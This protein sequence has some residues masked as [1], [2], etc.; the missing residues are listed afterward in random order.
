MEDVDARLLIDLLLDHRSAIH[1]LGQH[2]LHDESILRE[3]ILLC[4]N[5]EAILDEE[6]HVIEIG[7][8]P[9]SLT[10]HLLRTGAKVTAIEIEEEAINHLHRNFKQEIDDEKLQIHHGDALKINWP[11]S[12]HIVANIPYQISSP[13]IGKISRLSK[14][15]RPK[16]IVLLVQQEFAE[17]LSMQAGPD[18]VGSLGLTTGLDWEVSLGSVVPPHCFVPSPKV[19]SRL[20]RLTPR[21]D[22]PPEDFNRKLHRIVVRHVFEHRRRKVRSRLKEVPKR[23]QRVQGW[24]K[25]K[26]KSAIR[27]LE[28]NPP[29]DFDA[30]PDEISP[31]QWIAL[32]KELERFGV[33]FEPNS[34]SD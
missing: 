5:A 34:A 29:L 8:G 24:Y 13:L 1:S 14:S 7:P 22:A 2:F 26:W 28:E 3:A 23:I 27:F 16:C 12:T 4:E 6:S 19:H 11:K 17:K 32:I 9:G 15:E 20:V 31:D 25:S 30:R 33:D 18:S 10:L 21:T